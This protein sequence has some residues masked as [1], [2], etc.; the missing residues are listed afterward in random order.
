MMPQDKWERRRV[1]MIRRVLARTKRARRIAAVR[2]PSGVQ[3]RMLRFVAARRKERAR[4]RRKGG[5][6]T[7]RRADG[8]L[9]FQPRI[10]LPGSKKRV[11]IPRVFTDEAEAYAYSAAMT[12]EARK[13]NYTE[14]KV[15]A[16]A[17]G[18]AAAAGITCDEWHERYLTRCGKRIAGVPKKRSM[19]RKW[20]SPEVGDKDVRAV[21]TDD[22]ENIRDWL[23]EAIIAYDDDE[24]G[25]ITCESARKIWIEIQE[26]L[27][28]DGRLEAA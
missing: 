17:M 5:M 1:A 15:R 14:A 25:G 7:F 26:Q 3:K 18:A 22:I 20:A 9:C 24:L 12:E 21:T 2:G 19:W 27:P 6:Q 16:M 11:T 4:P 10:T 8:V 28:P 23:D 13:N